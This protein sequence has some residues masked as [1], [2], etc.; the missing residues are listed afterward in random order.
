MSIS[1]WTD[2]FWP[3]NKDVQLDKNQ[4]NPKL[5]GLPIWTWAS[6][7]LQNPRVFNIW[8]KRNLISLSLLLDSL[9]LSDSLS[10]VSP[11]LCLSF[12]LSL[13]LDFSLTLRLSFSPSLLFSESQSRTLSGLVASDLLVCM[14]ILMGFLINVYVRM[15]NQILSLGVSIRLSL[16]RRLDP[17]LDQLLKKVCTSLILLF[18]SCSVW[19]MLNL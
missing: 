10:R 8:G 6:N 9:R 3:K 12:S 1:N 2:H 11:S 14:F 13:R 4:L 17:T 5:L 15:L 19:L 7:N 18:H 16:F